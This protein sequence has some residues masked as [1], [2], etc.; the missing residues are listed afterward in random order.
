MDIYSFLASSGKKIVKG[1]QFFFRYVGWILKALI[2]A[3]RSHTAFSFEKSDNDLLIKINNKILMYK[4]DPYHQQVLMPSKGGYLL[5]HGTVNTDRM[6]F[7][8]CPEPSLNPTAEGE[9]IR[10]LDITASS[11]LIKYDSAGK[12]SSCHVSNDLY[13]NMRYFSIQQYK[14]FLFNGQSIS[15]VK[16][17]A[18]NREVITSLN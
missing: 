3:P 13:E 15:P 18:E 11:V 2:D 4:A 8:N 5:R 10:L 9:Q 12:I 14:Y 17:Q 6:V 16:A 1:L 7:E